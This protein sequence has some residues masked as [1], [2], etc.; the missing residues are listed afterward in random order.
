MKSVIILF[1][2]ILIVLLQGCSDDEPTNIIIQS[3]Y[4]EIT[5]PVM[6]SNVPDSTTIVITTNIEDLLRV[7]LYIDYS[8]RAVFREPPYEYSWDT[9]FYEDG[10]QHI[11]QA[12]A[13]DEGGNKLESKYVLVDVY[14]FMPS[15]LMAFIT[16]DS[17]ID[18]FWTDNCTFETGFEIEEAVNDSNFIKIAEVDSNITNYNFISEFGINNRYLFRMRAK[19]KDA[20]SGYSDIA[21]A[22]VMLN[23]PDNLDFTFMADT[24]AR[25]SWNDNND[26]ETGYVIEK[27]TYFGT[28]FIK[29]VPANTTET[30][31][32][33]SFVAGNYYTYY[34]HARMGYIHGDPSTFPHKTLQFNSPYNLSLEGINN[35][36]LKLRWH[37]DHSFETG[38]IVQ[39]SIDG[40]QYT[41]IG[42]TSSYNFTDNNLDTAFNYSYRI[43]A[44]SRYNISEPSN[45]IEAYFANQ[46]KQVNKFLIPEAI[47]YAAL[48]DDASTIAF[49]SYEG[50]N[51]VILVY[52]TFTG[53]HRFTL[54][55]D[56][57][58]SRI[59]LQITI[60]PDNRLLAA[61]GDDRYI[62]VWDISSGAV[63]TRISNVEY[64]HVLK[65]TPDGRYLI[66]EKRGTLKFYDVQ[67]WQYET[68][69]S[70]SYYITNID[71]DLN[72]NIIA[73]ADGRTN[74]NLWDYN[75]GIL[76]REIPQSVNA[77]PLEFNRSGTRIYSVINSDLFAW[78]VNSASVVLHI[79]N[80]LRRN[81]IAINEEENIAVGSYG[82]PGTGVWELSSGN[83]VQNLPLSIEE[84]F[85]SPDNYLIGRGLY[86]SYY[87]WEITGN[88]VSPIQ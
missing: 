41:E 22:A 31:I 38:Y 73:T 6:N 7:E 45:S 44:Y 61:A 39:R 78:D 9:R 55:V 60:R 11:L 26:F 16:S 36:S 54:S 21:V 29:E 77:H 1:S 5:S 10:S 28:V 58:L 59:F 82:S 30:V 35:N 66:V 63:I 74:I 68:R 12:L 53:Q 65:F 86:P 23:P 79:S 2:V 25:L 27:A 69:I 34:I 75:S 83:F 8:Q 48:S 37:Y 72:Q 81:S 3:P 56:D 40:L 4:L 43:A 42:R 47:S 33:D 50:N 67:T 52:D 17:S 18:L 71:I 80:F 64:P 76:I 32:S 57:S 46:L 20:F 15:N 87:I 19:S 51:P 13:Y 49:G 85:F 70:T 14:R 62:T 88:W 84:L 24:A